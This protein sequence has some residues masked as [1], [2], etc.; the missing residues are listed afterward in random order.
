MS[1]NIHAIC[2]VIIPSYLKNKVKKFELLKL[3]FSDFV[4]KMNYLIVKFVE[5]NNKVKQTD[6][7]SLEQFLIRIVDPLIEFYVIFLKFFF[8]A[9]CR[10]IYIYIKLI[11]SD[12]SKKTFV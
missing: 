7:Q 4:N 2:K 11:I 10:G 6:F 9:L 5:L 8:F 12:I 3:P 1:E